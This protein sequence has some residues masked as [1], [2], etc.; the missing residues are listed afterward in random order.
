MLRIFFTH[1]A[2]TSLLQDFAFYEVCVQYGP[3]VLKR[4]LILL[5]LQSIQKLAPQHPSPSASPQ[6]QMA[7]SPQQ[8]FAMPNP[9]AAPYGVSQHLGPSLPMMQGQYVQ[10]VMRHPS[11]VPSGGY[12]M[13]NSTGNF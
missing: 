6:P 8:A 13:P 5:Q 11:P 3:L 2:R 7:Q 12:G 1:P 4:Q 10:S 9:N